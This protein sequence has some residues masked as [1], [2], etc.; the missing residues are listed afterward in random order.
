MNDRRVTIR[1]S[2]PAFALLA[3][4]HSTGLFGLTVEAAAEELVLRGLREHID[5]PKLVAEVTMRPRKSELCANPKH[6]TRCCKPRR[7]RR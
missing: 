5:L 7:R 4:L 2:P 6:T 3:E 1:L